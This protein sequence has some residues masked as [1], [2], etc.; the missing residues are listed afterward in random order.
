MQPSSAYA[1]VQ[2]SRPP[3]STVQLIQFPSGRMCARPPFFGSTEM[4]IVMAQATPSA[5]RPFRIEISQASLDE[6]RKRVL[7]T[8]FP[9][10]ELVQDRSQ[11]V[12]LATLKALAN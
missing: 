6:L 1:D 12:Q 3:R 5:L 11:G 9:T 4:E 10:K 7:A 2:L 8:R